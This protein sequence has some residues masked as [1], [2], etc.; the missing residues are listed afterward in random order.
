M[1]L[2]EKRYEGT[3]YYYIRQNIYII[4]HKFKVK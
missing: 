2:I 1:K 4:S 3:N